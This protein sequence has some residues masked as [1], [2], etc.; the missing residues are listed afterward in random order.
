VRSPDF[1]NVFVADKHQEKS[2]QQSDYDWSG[3]FWILPLVKIGFPTSNIA[4]LGGYCVTNLKNSDSYNVST[5]LTPRWGITDILR[6]TTSSVSEENADWHEDVTWPV[7]RPFNDRFLQRL[8]DRAALGVAEGM[9][10]EAD[11][12]STTEELSGSP[13]RS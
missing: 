6:E 2:R 5:F 9:F 11:A 10:S 4:D 12:R 7:G 3:D 1:G 8:I 13:V